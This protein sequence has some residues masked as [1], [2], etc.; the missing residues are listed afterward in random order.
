MQIDDYSILDDEILADLIFYGEDRLPREFAAEV[1]SR[2]SMLPLLCQVV[3]D[4]QCWQQELPEW[5]AVVHST[6]ILGY[7]G[8]EDL[9]IPLLTVLRWADAYDCD[10]VTELLPSILGRVGPPMIPGLTAIVC[11]PAAGW[12]ARDLSMKGL[13][14]VSLGHP[15]SADHVFHIIGQRFM[16][17]HEDRLVRQLAAHILLDF[18]RMDYRLGLLKFAREEA[19][20]RATEMW[21]PTG[22]SPDEVEWAFKNPEPETHHYQDDWMRFYDPSE[23][24]RRQKRWA[25]E[26]LG[27]G[28]GRSQRPNPSGGGQVLPLNR[29]GKNPPEPPTDPEGQTEE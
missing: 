9:A 11:D 13:A 5:W 15:E 25:R 14:S 18:R 20:M 28:R 8:G 12:S 16:D 19:G 22:L 1:A 17:E 10:W 24:Q 3:M 7:R 21:Y 2:D 29:Q 27:A 26:R 23:I 4:K 6:F